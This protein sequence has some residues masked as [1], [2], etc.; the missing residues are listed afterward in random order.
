MV[1]RR[2]IQRVPQPRSIQ[3]TPSISS[4]DSAGLS[5]EELALL[6]LCGLPAY[7][8]VRTF[9][10]AFSSSSSKEK[11][12]PSSVDRVGFDLGTGQRSM[13]NSLS[14]YR[15]MSDHDIGYRRRALVLR[16]HD[17][18]GAMAVQM[19]VRRGWRVSVHVPFSS[20]PMNATQ[21]VGDQFM[22][23]TEER[24]REWGADEVIFDDGEG[25]GG[26]D[27]GRGAAVRVLDS[28]REDGDIF[29]AV[30][31]TIGGKE[32]REAAERLLRSTGV[33]T[34]TFDSPIKSPGLSKRR[35][36]GQFT[37]LVGDVPERAIPTAGDNFRAGLRSLRIGNDGTG[38]DAIVEETADT[39]AKVGYAWVSVAQDVDWEGDDVGETLGIVLRQALEA[40]VRPVVDDIDFTRPVPLQMTRTVPFEDTPFV[41]VDNGPLGDGGTVVVRIAA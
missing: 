10:Y 14:S 20:V 29:D 23:V 18:A 4:N 31:D 25:G 22:R 8:A 27:D 30:L 13:S 38:R 35:D 1:D 9:V 40:D 19:L 32:V 11:T 2:R 33:D 37:T 5:L 26:V 36:S 41:F 21:E 24:A 17:G 16:G 12:T 3:N 7:R 15:A 28:L 34:S 6:P 39:K